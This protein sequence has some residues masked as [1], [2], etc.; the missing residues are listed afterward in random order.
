MPRPREIQFGASDAHRYRTIFLSDMHLGTRGCQA[1]LML[2]FLRH[3]EADTYLPRRRHHRRLAH[4]GELV[5][6]AGA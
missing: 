1:Q 3:N 5:L 2:E 6:A 4:E